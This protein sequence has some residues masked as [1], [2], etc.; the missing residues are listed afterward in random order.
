M[1]NILLLVAQV[2][3]HKQLGLF[4]L[5]TKNNLIALKP[6][7]EDDILNLCLKPMINKQNL[8]CICKLSICKLKALHI[9]FSSTFTLTV[10]VQS[11][12]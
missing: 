12:N 4:L 6:Q 10:T 2:L 7:E 1:F 9:G 5:N 11:K 3:S 8:L